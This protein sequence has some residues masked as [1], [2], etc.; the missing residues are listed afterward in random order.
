MS[1][2]IGT[3]GS[4]YEIGRAAAVCAVTGRAL[5]PGDPIV[6]ALVDHPESDGFVRVD[7]CADAWADGQRPGPAESV[8]GFWRTHVPEPNAKKGLV[9]DATG[10]LDLF[11]QL[12]EAEDDTRLTL[13]FLVAL[14]LV[15]RREL[16]YE[17]VD[18]S[19][20]RPVLLVRHKGVAGRE[21]EP[22][23]VTEP[24]LDE[25]MLRGTLAAFGK[26]LNLEAEP[27]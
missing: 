25:E 5:G 14:T 12:A 16:V 15:R 24:G 22:M 6:A 9:I 13:R 10:L 23:R 8:F 3:G 26:A 27:S 4:G 7:L 2:A 21:G 1:S 19:G 11:E 17:G 20:G 18:R